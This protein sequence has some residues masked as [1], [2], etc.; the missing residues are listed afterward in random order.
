[1]SYES[2]HGDQSMGV[3]MFISFLSVASCGLLV[4]C[5]R[6]IR[7]AVPLR[8]CVDLVTGWGCDIGFLS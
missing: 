3:C 6:L 1:M 5:M 4:A 8:C 7:S 2:R